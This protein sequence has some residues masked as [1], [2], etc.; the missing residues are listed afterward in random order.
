MFSDDHLVLNLYLANFFTVSSR[1]WLAITIRFGPKRNCRVRT[2]KPGRKVSSWSSRKE[3]EARGCTRANPTLSHIKTD[4]LF[5]RLWSNW[6]ACRHFGLMHKL[7]D[8]SGDCSGGYFDGWFQFSP[9][10][11][12]TTFMFNSAPLNTSFHP[13]L[14]I[15]RR[16]WLGKLTRYTSNKDGTMKLIDEASIAWP[17][18]P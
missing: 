2:W 9:G 5:S 3:G 10:F 15:G 16:C 12:C 13:S 6:I 18:F 7:Q 4:R 11:L 8:D 14:R 17:C 1:N